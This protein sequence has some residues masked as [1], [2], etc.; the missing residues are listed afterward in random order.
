M[1]KAFDANNYKPDADAVAFWDNYKNVI[2]RD[3]EV[4]L[5]TEFEATVAGITWDDIKKNNANPKRTH[6]MLILPDWSPILLDDITYAQTDVGLGQ[7]VAKIVAG[8]ATVKN[9]RLYAFSM[10][11][12]G[13]GVWVADDKAN[14]I[15]KTLNVI[16]GKIN[17]C[18]LKNT[19]RPTKH[20]NPYDT[21]DPQ[22]RFR[23]ERNNKIFEIR[24]LL[25]NRMKK[26]GNGSNQAIITA[27]KHYIADTATIKLDTINGK[28]N[29]LNGYYDLSL[30][31]FCPGAHPELGFVRMMQVV[32]D[33]TANSQM[34]LD[35][36][37]DVTSKNG[38]H[39]PMVK[40]YLL[41][42][43]SSMFGSFCGDV[44][45]THIVLWGP[46]TNNGK[47]TL[48]KLIESMLANCQFENGY[49]SALAP[50]EMNQYSGDG[51][52]L[53]AGLS[54]CEGS[55]LIQISEPTKGMLMNCSLLKQISSGG[56]IAINP[57]YEKVHSYTFHALTVC[58]CNSIPIYSDSSVWTSGRIKLVDFCWQPQIIDATFSERLCSD[59]SN[60]ATLYNLLLAA[61]YDYVD[62]GRKF[63][64]P[65]ELAELVRINSENNNVYHRFLV[66]R[67]VVTK[68]RADSIGV[69]RLAK[70]FK[71][72]VSEEY[73]RQ[74]TDNIK[75][76]LKEELE[77]TP[78]VLVDY[79]NSNTLTAYG[80]RLRT[81]ED[82]KKKIQY[83]TINDYIF[84]FRNIYLVEDA[85][86]SIT[87]SDLTDA[88]TS[89]FTT[90]NMDISQIMDDRHHDTYV[91]HGLDAAVGEEFAQFYTLGFG[92][93]Q[94]IRLATS[95]ECKEREIAIAKKQVYGIITTETSNKLSGAVLA[96]L[97][98]D[99][100][101]AAI[102]DAIITD[103]CNSQLT[104]EDELPF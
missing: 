2:E 67:C 87:L 94:D 13:G 24:E 53:T 83:M 6:I 75:S 10:A 66:Q 78:G 59:M 54:G 44:I 21:S 97:Q 62:R 98:A 65:A 30:R 80:I 72:F 68:H 43:V 25:T 8:Y 56:A 81:P 11:D 50:K 51:S 91:Q 45:K 99:R 34:L 28:I 86:E 69:L 100:T 39:R 71:D 41:E 92:F 48:L 37:D 7:A 79:D 60:R 38:S 40:K 46:T 33:P 35:F 73:D 103:Y 15:A 76:K 58:D 96:A 3:Y 70:E 5:Y 42:L 14:C 36:L 55:I 64:E 95:D 16:Q 49:Y 52:S 27:A 22:E 74:N 32:Y 18:L 19:E 104:R 29:M 12:E 20:Q 84:E 89:F 61:Y 85:G 93:L 102:L 47:S 63:A 17:E 1:L 23:R 88:L 57:K 77:L 9:D 101:A 31:S 82:I 4:K 26:A 90:N